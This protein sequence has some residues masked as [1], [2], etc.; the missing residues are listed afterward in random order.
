MA[1]MAANQMYVKRIE[2]DSLCGRPAVALEIDLEA[3]SEVFAA[4]PCAFSIERPCTVDGV[5][6][7]FEAELT[8]GLSISNAPPTVTP[9][10]NHRLL[11]LEKPVQLAEGALLAARLS[12]R[13]GAV[14][15][16]QMATSVGAR[17]PNWEVDQST[18]G[19]LP[20]DLHQIRA[21]AESCIPQRG[22]RSEAAATVL[23]RFGSGS[24]CDTIAQALMEQYPTEFPTRAAA[25]TFVGE[26]A[27]GYGAE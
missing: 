19:G 12:T 16:W 9:S 27:R 15:R 24:A 22:V 4:G 17:G 10:W 5:A 14:W 3:V 2:A 21:Q 6:L 18:F 1:S 25:Q 13:D 11:P 8:P 26:L 23:A 20:P 7:W